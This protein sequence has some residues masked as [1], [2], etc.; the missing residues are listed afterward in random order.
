MRYLHRAGATCVGV[1]ERE[2]SIVNPQGIDPKALEEY[3][4]DNGSIVGF[5][6]SEPYTGENLMFEPCDIFIP[7]AIE[8]VINK[9]NAGRI[10]AKVYLYLLLLGNKYC[11]L[12]LFAFLLFQSEE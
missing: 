11:L 9:E 3:R 4:N 2:G 1:I 10:Q 12:R 8:K 7:A 5:P 6:G